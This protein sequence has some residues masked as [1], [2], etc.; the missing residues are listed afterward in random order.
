V[1]K[2]AFVDTETLGLDPDRHAIWEV[3]AVIV[4]RTAYHEYRTDVEWQVEVT[5]GMIAAA[6]PIGREI[7]GFDSRYSPETATTPTVFAAEF[8]A[9]TA[10]CHLLGAVPSF[11]EERLRRQLLLPQGVTPAW[12]YH[13]IDVE[14]LVVGALM[15]RGVE[16][17]LP[18][19]SDELSRLV[20]VEPEERHTA[21]GDAIWALRMYQALNPHRPEVMT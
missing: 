11:D 1:T 15:D 21:L 18:W 17:E 16:L 14:T 13:L 10:G 3:A 8:A 2:L 9:L 6:D 5:D 19:D 7:S 4:E 12:H 20:G